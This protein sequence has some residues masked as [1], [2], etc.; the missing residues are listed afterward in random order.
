M[1]W[2]NKFMQLF[3]SWCVLNSSRVLNVIKTK[4][5]ISLALFNHLLHCHSNCKNAPIGPACYRS[6]KIWNIQLNVT[7]RWILFSNALQFSSRCCCCCNL[8][9]WQSVHLVS[10]STFQNLF[11]RDLFSKCPWMYFFIRLKFYFFFNLQFYFWNSCW[12]LT[13]VRTLLPSK[14][15][16]WKKIWKNE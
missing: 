15:N 13:K 6:I 16:E 3:V 12:S 2:S 1:L 11:M 7:F 4:S 8:S 5:I 14:M 10:S 9:A